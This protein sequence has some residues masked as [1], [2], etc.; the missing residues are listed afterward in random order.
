M[1]QQSSELF[2][3]PLI[4]KLR[5]P[6]TSPKHCCNVNFVSLEM[7]SRE[8]GLESWKNQLQLRHV[9]VSVCGHRHVA[10]RGYFFVRTTRLIT[11]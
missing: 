6:T 3:G 8:V 5:I 2:A 10:G 7:E 11:S 4:N 1:P 9:K